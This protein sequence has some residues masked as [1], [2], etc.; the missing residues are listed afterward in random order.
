MKSLTG[1]SQV[2]D[3]CA[4]ATLQSNYF[5]GAPPDDCFC[6]KIWSQYNCNK[7]CRKFKS[8]LKWRS[9]RKMN[10]NENLLTLHYLWNKLSKFSNEQKKVFHAY[11]FQLC[12]KANSKFAFNVSL[13][14]INCF[15][16]ETLSLVSKSIYFSWNSLSFIYGD[17]IIRQWPKK[18][19]KLAE[20]FFS[21]A[22]ITCPVQ[23]LVLQTLE[24]LILQSRDFQSRIAS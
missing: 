9:S 4:K 14:E 3:K 11:S 15:K 16:F 5:R 23:Q 17:V 24:D 12:S 21:I 19:F 22:R 18:K 1:I 6:L 2:F 13:Y 10:K 8:I 20:L 7:K